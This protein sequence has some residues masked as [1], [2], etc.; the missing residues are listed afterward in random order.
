M[1]KLPIILAYSLIFFSENLELHLA[2][3]TPAAIL[4]IFLKLS[5]IL[6][7]LPPFK[8]ELSALVVISD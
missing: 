5:L 2:R 6:R 8:R 3:S 1:A 4:L 7:L